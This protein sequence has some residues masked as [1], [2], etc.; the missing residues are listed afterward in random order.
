MKHDPI[1]Y[2][3]GRFVRASQATIP[4]H[5]LS[6]LR[7][8]AL[9][10]SLRTYHRKPFLLREHVQRLYYA[11]KYAGLN[12]P[13]SAL[14]YEKTVLRTIQKNK[15]NDALLRLYVTGGP[16]TSLLPKGKAGAII[17]VD[18]LH[19]FPEWQYTKGIALMTSPFRRIYPE[20]KS[21]VYF[22]A[23]KES[24]LATKRG[25][26][27][28][29]FVDE[30]GALLEGTTYSVFA[31]LPGPRLVTA[32]DQVLPGI[33][34]QT[35]IGV[36]KRLKIPVQRSPITSAMLRRSKEVFITSSN[37][38]LIPVVRID[39]KRIGQ[40]KP[41]EVTQQLHRAYREVVRKLTMRL[42]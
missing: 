28:V 27:E 32:K 15:F 18:P 2:I 25:F 22:A 39:R 37:R 30:Q 35:V 7:G 1:Y 26:T 9:F 8:Y 31:V 6:F 3:N 20:I 10:D 29:V 21:T 11:V 34:A 40:G 42:S 5:D 12:P 24:L 36:A 38:E 4:I 17:M 19:A 33:T 14:A 23:V 16:S 41:G 13:M